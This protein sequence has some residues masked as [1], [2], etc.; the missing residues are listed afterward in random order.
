M[1]YEIEEI[2]GYYVAGEKMIKFKKAERNKTL[3]I[4]VK[5]L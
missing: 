1:V 5:K 3:I 4:K 2:K